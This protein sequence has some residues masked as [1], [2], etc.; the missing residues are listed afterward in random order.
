MQHRNL[1]SNV[2]VQLPFYSLQTCFLLSTILR[3]KCMRLPCVCSLRAL[4][5]KFSRGKKDRQDSIT[6]KESN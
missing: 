4:M 3:E 2:D 1:V 6:A 5:L